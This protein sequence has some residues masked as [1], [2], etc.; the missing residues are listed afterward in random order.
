MT[1]HVESHHALQEHLRGRVIAEECITVDHVQVA[2]GRVRAAFG[3]KRCGRK[4]CE[5]SIKA[6]Q[7]VEP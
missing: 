2:G 7:L 3:F 1:R 5:G 6:E 4:A